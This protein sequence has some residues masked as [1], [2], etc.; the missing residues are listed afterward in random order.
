MA[1]QREGR[2][3]SGRDSGAALLIMLAVVAMGGLSLAIDALLIKSGRLRS[4]Q[5]SSYVLSQ[6]KDTLVASAVIEAGAAGSFGNLPCPYSGVLSGYATAA[7]AEA[8]C[9]ANDGNIAIGFL[10]WQSLKLPP[11]FDGEGA[12]IWYAVSG[13]FKTGS[14]QTDI[15]PY[16]VCAAGNLTINGGGAYAAILFSP[17]NVLPLLDPTADQSRAQGSDAAAL[18]TQFLEGEN[19]DTDTDFAISRIMTDE[20][21]GVAAPPFNDR[22]LGVTCQEI[23]DA[24]N[25]L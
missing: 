22:L 8:A 23:I 7:S 3:I 24:V 9:G 10:P 5:R 20:S 19:A 25:S 13:V 14:G 6:A 21:G 1:I 17:G 11:L 12:Q 16:N 4:D 2:S 18:W 15:T